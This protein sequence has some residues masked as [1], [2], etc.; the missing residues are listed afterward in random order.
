MWRVLLFDSE[1]CGFVVPRAYE[2]REQANEAA[3]QAIIGNLNATKGRYQPKL[4]AEVVELHAQFNTSEETRRGWA[5]SVVFDWPR[6]RP[7]MDG[8]RPLVESADAYY[9]HG[10]RSLEQI[11]ND[12]G[13]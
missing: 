8:R 4:K 9:K 3:R 5:N 11:I 12:D 6:Y 7:I 1:T 2:T 13:A 10:G